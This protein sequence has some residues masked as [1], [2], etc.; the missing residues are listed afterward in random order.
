L[1]VVTAHQ[2]A[3][4]LWDSPY[5]NRSML[6]PAWK[7][8]GRGIAYLSILFWDGGLFDCARFPVV[9]IG[10]L[11]SACYCCA[12][13]AVVSR[14]EG[15][16][17]LV[18][19]PP[20]T[21]LFFTACAGREV[22]GWLFDL[23]PVLSSLHV[24]RF[25]LAVHLFG[26]VTIAVGAGA[27]VR[28]CSSSTTRQLAAALLVVACVWPALRE[29]YWMYKST[30]TRHAESARLFAGESDLHR[31]LMA[32]TQLP[33]GWTY[34]G[35][36]TS[37]Q[38]SLVA[39]GYIP[40]DVF[41]VS[42]GVPTVGG[43][44]F[45]AFSLAGET[46]FDF[47][48]ARRAH[49]D[50]FGIRNIVAPAEW[51]APADFSK[52]HTYGPY[53]VWSRGSR[54]LFVADERFAATRTGQTG[55]A[56]AFVQG[57]TTLA[58][59]AGEVTA[60]T[61]AQPWQFEGTAV[62]KRAGTIVAAVGYHPN[63][64]ATVDGRPTPTGWCLPGFVRISVPEGEHRVVL[65]YRPSSSKVYLVFLALVVIGTAFDYRRRTSRA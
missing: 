23:V 24:H 44:L 43:I 20:L 27:L 54:M 11:V 19:A 52:V 47:D 26:I 64:E 9:T 39:A 2:W 22:W 61:M 38:K 6:E 35:S 50:L 18:W 25:A 65:R 42:R 58:S 56:R 17:F 15:G 60:Q 57:V 40:L 48:P 41:T 13:R 4:V 21:A 7:Y 32:V 63:W 8:E 30:F 45:H 53:G 28:R 62:M 37:W 34:I 16:A 51:T 33:Y 3:F 5:I 36:S 12:Y 59:D 1:A 14:R 10:L 46:L 49:F 29:R 55:P 31:T